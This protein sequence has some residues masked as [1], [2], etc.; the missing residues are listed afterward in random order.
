MFLNIAYITKVNLASLNGAE[1]SGGNIT[2]IK[3][4]SSYD[5]EEYAY[6]SGQA[7]RRYLKETLMQ[8]GAKITEINEKGEPTFKNENGK[9]INLDKDFEKVKEIAFKE[10]VDL[11]LF[12]YMFPNGTRRWSPVKVAPMLSILPYKGEVDFLTRK[13]KSD[14]KRSGN[15]VQ[16]EIDTLNFA[17]GN[18]LI[19]LDHIGAIVD[20]YSYEKEDILNEDEKKQR[21]NLLLEAIKNFNG[22]AKLAR[23]L[24]DISPKFIV[25]ARQ[26]TGNPFLLNVLKVDETGALDIESLKEAIKDAE[27][28]ELK[29]GLTKGI[30]SNEDQIKNELD[31]VS[32]KEAIDY[33]KV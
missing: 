29:I 25:I 17:R 23:N 2:P 27:V 16:I 12:G 30:F 22:G 31:V 28:D 6:V 8:L 32:V 18:I 10:Y 13:Q 9:Y 19:N 5:G 14:G 4:I 20:E 3:K 33:F 24:E 11:D 21:I 1:G 15:I 26:K 7:L